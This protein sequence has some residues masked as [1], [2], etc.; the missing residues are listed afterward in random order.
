MDII[1][2]MHGMQII[3]HTMPLKYYGVSKIGHVIKPLYHLALNSVLSC[4][5]CALPIV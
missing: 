5:L 2:S 4:L 3:S 1:A